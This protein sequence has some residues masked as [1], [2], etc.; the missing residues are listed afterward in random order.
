[1]GRQWVG[2]STKE[3]KKKA[4]LIVI[5][6]VIRLNSDQTLSTIYTISVLSTL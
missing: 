2:N 3:E 4:Q 6:T 5:K 1:M